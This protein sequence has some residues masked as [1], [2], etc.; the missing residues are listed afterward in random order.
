MSA[1]SSGSSAAAGSDPATN[2][3][4]FGAN[5]WL[6]EELYQ[7]YLADPGSVDRAWWSFFADYTPALANG[8]GPQPV[9]TA[10]APPQPSQAPPPP[11]P[12]AAQ[13]AAPAPAPAQ[14]PP[15]AAPPAAAPQAAA[16][17]A[18]AGAEISRLRG[19]AAR[20]VTNM[21]AS[22]SVPTATSVRSVPAKLLADNRIVINNHLKR[23][24]GG[25]VSFTHL[26][27]YAVSRRSRRC[28]R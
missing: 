26:I 13:A 20:T 8:T 6:V 7:R 17:P 15:A 21:T 10:P 9:I 2:Q 28:R 25:K 18:V 1:V 23:G 19:S 5:E 12:Q 3:A 14:A 16:P 22:L 27:G 24:R 4:N 11:P